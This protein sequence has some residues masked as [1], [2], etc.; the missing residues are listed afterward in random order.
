[1]RQLL[2]AAL[3]F[4]G[5]LA[6]AQPAVAQ[7]DQSLLEFVNQGISTLLNDG[8]VKQILESYGVPFYPPIS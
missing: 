5:A 8:K 4:A 1:M 7:E 2:A 3:A 6:G